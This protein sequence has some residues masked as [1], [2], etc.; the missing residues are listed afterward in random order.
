MLCERCRRV[1]MPDKIYI[2]LTNRLPHYRLLELFEIAIKVVGI[3]ERIVCG[4]MR[5]KRTANDRRAVV[6]LLYGN[7]A[8]YPQIGEL[9]GHRDH[10]SIRHLNIQAV[11]GYKAERAGIAP[12]GWFVGFVK[13]KDRFDAM[14]REK[15]DAELAAA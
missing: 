12:P 6:F 3:P 7:G 13:I 10:S 14:I 9:L 4:R 11:K 15:I 5:D 8:S 2:R 1:M